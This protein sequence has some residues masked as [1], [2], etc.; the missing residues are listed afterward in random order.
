[1]SFCVLVKLE[2]HGW[3]QWLR[4]FAS[5]ISLGLVIARFLR[6]GFGLPPHAFGR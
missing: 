4:I 2:L 1:M 6:I 3:M 5:Y